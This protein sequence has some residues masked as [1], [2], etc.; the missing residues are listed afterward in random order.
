ME[1]RVTEV[2]NRDSETTWLH[3]EDGTHIEVNPRELYINSLENN[4]G[5]CGDGYAMQRFLI[6]CEKIA[7]CKEDIIPGSEILLEDGISPLMTKVLAGGYDLIRHE[8]IIL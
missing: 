1:Q 6:L 8:L 7:E 4:P 2:D 5:D 3:L